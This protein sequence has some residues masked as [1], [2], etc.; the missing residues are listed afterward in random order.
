MTSNGSGPS[1]AVG[2]IFAPGDEN[3]VFKDWNQV[4]VP[5]CTS[6]LHSGTGDAAEL[7]HPTGEGPSYTTH[8]KG[9]HVVDA[10][11]DELEAG[12]VSDDG[13]QTMPLLADADLVLMIGS[14]AGGGGVSL[15]LDRVAD[16]FPDVDI[17]GIIDSH[18]FPQTE[19]FPDEGSGTAPED[20]SGFLQ[21]TWDTTY[22]P[23]W[24]SRPDES[25][26]EANPEGSETA[27]L[28]MD[29]AYLQMNHLTTPFFLRQDELDSNLS[30]AFRAPAPDGS[31]ATDEAYSTAVATYLIAVSQA[32]IDGIEAAGIESAPGIFGPRCERHTALTSD[33]YFIDD[34]IT[35][36]ATESSF[37]DAVIDWL[38]GSDALWLDPPGEGA[39]DRCP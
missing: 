39:M 26:Q 33:T 3:N 15:N 12:A 38:T 31:G 6:D 17:R 29:T 9:H 8:F 14:S 7:S 25:C 24:Q 19:H 28:C 16:R 2:G 4:Y 27:W 18:G 30:A 23:L 22:V 10:V 20:I 32:H 21:S 11:Y 5:Y 34:V 36:G 37:Q 35:S 1:K 13:A